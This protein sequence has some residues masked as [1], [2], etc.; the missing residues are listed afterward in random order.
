MSWHKRNL[1]VR[2]TYR[3]EVR[4]RTA[5]SHMIPQADYVEELCF[6]EICV[7]FTPSLPNPTIVFASV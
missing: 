1:E 6:K 4:M 7:V 5:I 3:T 2:P